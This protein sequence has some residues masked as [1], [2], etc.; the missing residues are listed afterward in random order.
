[1]AIGRPAVLTHVLERRSS[2]RENVRM[3]SADAGIGSSSRKTADCVSLPT[4]KRSARTAAALVIGDWD[5]GPQVATRLPTSPEGLGGGRARA[6][7]CHPSLTR[8]LHARSSPVA[9]EA[10][11]TGT[12]A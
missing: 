3:G 2:A 7:P 9:T 12:G 5:T 4:R 1:M 6:P 8:T 10:E 11:G